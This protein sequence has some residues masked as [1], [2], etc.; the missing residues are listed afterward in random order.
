LIKKS[1]VKIKGLVK[2]MNVARQRL[3]AGIPLAEQD[4]FRDWIHDL[5]SQVETICRESK[6]SPS[7]LPAPSYRAYCY[8][9]GL[10]LEHLPTVREGEEPAER[11]VQIQG[12]VALCESIQTRLSN[13]ALEDAG[14]PKTTFRGD[15]HFENILTTI[16]SAVERTQAICQAA[17]SMP[18]N[19]PA[20]SQRAYHWLKF[21]S[22]E[23]VLETHLST[24]Q[25][26]YALARK[27]AQK[28]GKEKRRLQ[29][30]FYNTRHL[31][32]QKAHAGALN[33]IIHEAFMRA[34]SSVLE[35]ILKS[36]RAGDPKRYR[37]E[38]YQYAQ[39]EA[40]TQISQKL[41]PSVRIIN[42]QTRG[43]YFDLEQIF[44]R[45][46]S[47]YFEGH[48]VKP[49]LTWNETLTQRKLGHY[50]PNTDTVM[51]SISLDTAQTPQF[52]MDFILYHELLHKQLGIKN[53]N[54]RR[55]AHTPAFRKAEAKFKQYQQAQDYLRKLGA[56]GKL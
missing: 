24:L 44:E 17:Q 32:R 13:L 51:V 27:L 16:Q 22:Q 42:Q 4:E 12:L 23:E 49:R 7:Q 20:P 38:I 2:A 31:Y 5:I 50:D 21:L 34:P 9:K 36:V 46:N 3:A 14:G 45:V 37:H 48:M 43:R 33:L 54:G 8:M 55:Y 25:R 39:R 18:S 11:Q 52:M 1:S 6:L 28:E 15:Q 40:F 29:I 30:D 56:Q 26:T 53:V 35:A 19:L 47:Q 41:I 10:D